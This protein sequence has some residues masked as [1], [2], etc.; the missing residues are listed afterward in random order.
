MVSG[1]SG[2]PEHVELRQL[3]EKSRIVREKTE[4][5]ISRIMGVLNE[6][7]PHIGRALLA[8]VVRRYTGRG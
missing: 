8:E 4:E 1:H 6:V 7:P 3:E 2:L 5:R